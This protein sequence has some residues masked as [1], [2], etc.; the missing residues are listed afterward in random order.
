M[1]RDIP[2]LAALGPRPGQRVER[3]GALYQAAVSERSGCSQ[4]GGRTG[5]AS[6]A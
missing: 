2:L 6:P 4:A 1:F 3:V 5:G